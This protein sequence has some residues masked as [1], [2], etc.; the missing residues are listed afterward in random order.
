M[1]EY[2]VIPVYYTDCCTR[3]LTL[4]VQTPVRCNDATARPL[5]HLTTILAPNLTTDR[6]QKLTRKWNLYLSRDSLLEVLCIFIMYQ[7]FFFF[8]HYNPLW[9]FFFCVSSWAIS[10]LPTGF[11]DHTQRRATV[12][13]TPLDVWSVRRRDL[14][15]TTHNSHNRQI[16]MPQVGFEPTIAAGDRP[17]TYAFMYYLYYWLIAPTYVHRFQ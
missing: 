12:D 6:S 16:S 3:E 4:Q 17:S 8:L 2:I 11:L 7:L 14:Y 13:R 10:S 1:S 5:P 9:V 15:R